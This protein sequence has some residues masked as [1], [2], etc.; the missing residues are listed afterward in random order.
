ML[1][2]RS[3]KSYH[4]IFSPSYGSSM[5]CLV[6]TIAFLS[7]FFL[8]DSQI[9]IRNPQHIFMDKSSPSWCINHW[10]PIFAVMG[11]TGVGK[12]TFI[13]VLG[14][15]DC[16]NRPP[17]IDCGGLFSCKSSKEETNHEQKALTLSSR[18]IESDFLQSR[19][20][21]WTRSVPY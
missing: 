17:R 20:R 2:A 9:D 8:F 14:G 21:E 16:D 4:R 7:P 15:R 3:H 12:S 13:D 18:H 19:L 6:V 10:L 5:I 11:K 1:T